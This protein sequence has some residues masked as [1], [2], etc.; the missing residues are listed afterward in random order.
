MDTIKIGT[1]NSSL[2]K[3]QVELLIQKLKSQYSGIKIEI[4][5]LSTKGDDIKDRELKELGGKDL[6]IST[7]EEKLLAG[8]IDIA[9]HSAKDI[10]G[11]LNPQT[12][13]F[14]PLE[15]GDPR[16][17][18]VSNH[19]SELISLGENHIIGTSSPRRS[20]LIAKFCNSQIKTLRGN[21]GT[22][23]ENIKNGKYTATILAAAGLK[24]LGVFDNSYM[25]MLPVE[26]F[27]PAIGQGIIAVQAKNDNKTILELLKRLNNNKVDW[28][29]N[30][31]RGFLAGL[32]GNCFTP[33]GAYS[34]FAR[35][36]KLICNYLAFSPDG[37]Q[38]TEVSKISSGPEEAFNLG[39][40]AAEEMLQRSDTEF[41]S[42]F[43]DNK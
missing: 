31:E 20:A 15:R 28:Q 24:R 25:T 37:R 39:I 11:K 27:C 41:L 8:E 43:I 34:W 6:F 42:Q 21:V 17:V 38:T 40:E 26:E 18:L 9:V 10:S 13:L 5:P 19:H 7:I 32:G 3:L 4:I 22:R 1:R 35:E 33:V 23:L 16:D 2:A 29:M 36:N 30:A 14:T 12:S